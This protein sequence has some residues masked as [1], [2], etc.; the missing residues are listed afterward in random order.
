[1]E[2]AS[3]AVFGDSARFQVGQLGHIGTGRIE[4]PD[5]IAEDSFFDVSQLSC[6]V[7]PALLIRAATSK[8]PRLGQED[9][10]VWPARKRLIFAFAA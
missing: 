9:L 4:H 5:D 1:M 6:S 10:D 8:C 2:G 3:E 7:I